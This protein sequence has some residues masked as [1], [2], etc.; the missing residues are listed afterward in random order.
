MS[1]IM[2][3]SQIQLAASRDCEETWLRLHLGW[4]R[5]R[6]RALVRLMEANQSFSDSSE[7]FA[8][9]GGAQELPRGLDDC[10]A[11]CRGWALD[12]PR[13]TDRAGPDRGILA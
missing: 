13:K 3:L 4:A 8:K 7:G 6:D 2:G 5:Q 10:I 11:D 12:K 9:V 1:C